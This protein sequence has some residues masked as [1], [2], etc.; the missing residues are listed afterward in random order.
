MSKSIWLLQT[1]RSGNRIKTLTTSEYHKDKYVHKWSKS[2][3]LHKYNWII[4][5]KNLFLSN[6]LFVYPKLFKVIFLH[7]F[8]R[9]KHVIIHIDINFDILTSNNTNFSCTRQIFINSVLSTYWFAIL[10]MLYTLCWTFL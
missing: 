5:E 10:Q 4:I 8:P 1:C 3:T 6:G 2:R 9:L 7:A